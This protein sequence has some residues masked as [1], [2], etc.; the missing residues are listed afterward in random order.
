MS[1]IKS[2]L[3]LQSTTDTALIPLCSNPCCCGI[4]A[5]HT[6][7]VLLP[8]GPQPQL[9]PTLHL[10]ITQYEAHEDTPLS[11]QNCWCI[12]SQLLYLLIRTITS[13]I[14]DQFGSLEWEFVGILYGEERQ[15]WDLFKARSTWRFSQVLIN[16][17]LKKELI[18][19]Q[20]IWWKGGKSTLVI[21]FLLTCFDDG[22][23]FAY[24]TCCYN[25][26]TYLNPHP[27]I[28]AALLKAIP[29]LND[30]NWSDW[31]TSMGMYFKAM[32]VKE[33]MDNYVPLTAELKV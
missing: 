18:P 27:S 13:I 17:V 9:F 33:I 11:Y 19:C 30:T 1:S 7:Q 6:H 10:T 4:Y 24:Y 12:I 22:P 25:L 21:K 28:P 20:E 16:V 14:I 2:Y 32:K 15:N 3:P 23:R 5:E 26:I 29:T 31:S 8:K